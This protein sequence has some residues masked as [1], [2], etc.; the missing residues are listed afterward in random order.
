MKGGEFSAAGLANV[1]RV[2]QGESEPSAGERLLPW[3]GRRSAPSWLDRA[4]GPDLASPGLPRG[5]GKN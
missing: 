1:D 2:I 3:L 5:N 4:F